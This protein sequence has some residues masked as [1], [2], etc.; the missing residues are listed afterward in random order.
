MKNAEFASLLLEM[1]TLLEL[2]KDNPFRIRAYQRAAQAIESLSKDIAET[3]PEELLLVPGIGKGVAE[4]I[5]E[6]VKKGCVREHESLKREFPPGLLS[7]L[8]VS[9]LGPK[10]ARILYDKLG[11][12]SMEALQRAASQKKL[13]AIPGF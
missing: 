2:K 12:D 1:A 5:S 4:K 6:F 10:R 11:I 13:Q 8:K 9:G 7:V 3:P